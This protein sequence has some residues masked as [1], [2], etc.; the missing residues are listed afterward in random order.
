MSDSPQTPGPVAAGEAEDSG[1]ASVTS[2]VDSGRS[3][4]AVVG[5]AAVIIVTATL[6]GRL[7]GLARD[8]VVANFFGARPEADAF[9]LAFRVPYLLA[10][11]VTGALPATFVR[12]FC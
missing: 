10:L 7:L 3:V 4:R 2:T 1:P 8:M 9:F 11:L 12:L 5:R 6:V